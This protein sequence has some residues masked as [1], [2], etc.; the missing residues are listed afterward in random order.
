M[1]FRKMISNRIM[2]LG[3]VTVLFVS[4]ATIINM[5]ISPIKQYIISLKIRGFRAVDK[6]Y[7]E[8][9]NNSK[10]Y[11]FYKAEDWDSFLDMVDGGL[12]YWV[13]HGEGSN[14]HVYIDSGKGI[15]WS[16]LP[17]SLN[18]KTPDSHSVTICYF[19]P[20]LIEIPH[21]LSYKESERPFVTIRYFILGRLYR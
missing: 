14:F 5:Q 8:D 17:H 10:Y 9:W 20:G 4:I 13:K 18:Y 21:S 19:K 12:R 16:E 7:D 15:F 1:A 6:T 11:Y 2:L 3:A